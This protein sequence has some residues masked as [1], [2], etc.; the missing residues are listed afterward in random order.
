MKKRSSLLVIAILLSMI[1]PGV[2]PNTAQAAGSLVTKSYTAKM[3]TMELEGHIQYDGIHDNDGDGFLSIGRSN[4]EFGDVRLRAGVTFD[5]G[6]P[7]GNVVSAE[8]VLTVA[9]VIRNPDHT[10]YMEARG[11]AANELTESSF[12]AVDINSPYADKFTAKSIAEVPMGTYLQNQSITFNV[13]SAVDAFTDSSDRKI[14]FTLN[15]NEANAASG[16]FSIHSLE[17]FGNA[18][19]RPKLIVT[20]DTGVTA[21]NPLVGSFTITEG[22]ATSAGTVNLSVTG[23]DPDAGDSITHMRFA[24]SAAN[25]SAASWL[26]FSNT[27]T[28][29]LSGGDGSKTIYMQLK[30]SK[31]RISAN[32]SQTILLDQTAPIGTLIINDGATWTKSNE[33]TLKG[34]YTDGSGPGVEQVRLSNISGGSWQTSWFSIA[35]LNGKSWNLPVGEGTKTVY[36]QYKDKVGNVSTATISSTISVDTIAPIISNVEN[37]K[38]YKSKVIALFNEGFGL[39]NGSPYTSGTDITQDGTYTLTV[40]DPTGNSAMV[41]FKVDTTAPVVSGVTNNG[42]YKSNVTITFNKGTATLNGA[43]FSSGSQVALDGM[44][45]LVVT[46]AAGNVTTI[47]FEID[48]VAPTVTGVTNGWNYKEKVTVGFNEGTA[49]LNGAAF[50]S[51]TEIDQDGMYTLVVTDAVGNVTTVSF[52]IDSEDPIVTGVT[53]GGIYKGNVTVNFNEGTAK[54]NGAAFISGTQVVQD[55]V[56]T[57]VVTDAAGNETTITFEIDKLA[58]TVTGVT[59]NGDYKEAVTVTFNEGTA[60]LNSAPFAS[61]TEIDQDGVYTL[62]VTDAAGNVT[63]MNFKIDQSPPVVTGVVDGQVYNGKVTVSFNEGTATLNGVSFASGTAIIQDGTYTLVVTDE[64]GNVTTVSFEID[65]IAPIVTG[66]TN[67]G[68]YKEK[69]TVGFNEGTATLNGIAFTKGTE[70]VLD[71]AYTLVVTDEAGNITTIQFLLDT[72]TP[73]GTVII[74]SGVEWTNI[75][76]AILTLTSDDGIEGSGVVEMRFSSN[77]TDWSN[78]EPS[79]GTKGWTLE[80]GDG[81][82]KVFVQFKDKVGNVSSTVIYDSI[83]LDQTIPSGTMVINGGAATTSSKSVKLSLTSS[84]GVGSG[85]S[86]MRFSSD[87]LTWSIWESISSMKNWNLNGDTGVKKIFVQFRDVA[88]NMSETSNAVIEYQV[89]SGSD[90]KDSN[91]G[92]SGGAGNT[93]NTSNSTISSNGKITLPTGG[94]G[95]VSLNGEITISI[96]V[97]AT[98]KKLELEIEKVK[99]MQNMLNKK[100]ILASSV[101]EVDSNYLE[102]FKK[103]VTLTMSFDSLILN[104][105]KVVAIFYYDEASKGWL[106]VKDGKISGN[107]I[108]V[109]MIDHIKKKYAVLVVDK[110]SGLPAEQLIDRTTEANLNDV[111]GHWAETSIKKAMSEGI[112]KGYAD[113]SFRPN[114][115]VTRAEFAVMLINALKPEGNGNELSFIDNEKIGDWAHD[116]V[117]QAVQADIIKGYQDGTFR[118]NT[119]LTRAEMASIIANVLKLSVE[120]S[121]ATGFT[122][123]KSIPTWANNAVAQLNKLGLIEGKGRNKFEP[124]ATT[125][126]AEAVTVLLKMLVQVSK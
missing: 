3:D 56:Y 52:K 18:A 13:K 123:D 62:V 68:N 28:F 51:G 2:V 92:S 49:M 82:K 5:L 20:Y 12:P 96:P 9:T 75:T 112:V 37:G 81:E 65:K 44:H 27:A 63:T 100:E 110:V 98:T 38:V 104:N 50:A 73:I 83:K 17:T 47:T 10:L 32:S 76:N 61:G 23:S 120:S 41:N 60:T 24:N 126:R 43:A 72:N 94:A 117:A 101:Y 21:N 14:T 11:S 85:I 40:T 105:N 116:A 87:E 125:T 55:G 6:V 78:W 69:V 29:S 97:N 70:I 77:G 42:I 106:K 58:P 115:T 31:D 118:P 36:V 90:H 26:P 99:N 4:D 1:S 79:A 121:N 107:R 124:N 16:W 80:A 71:G 33:V 102:N 39:L 64:A 74:H 25:L 35:D 34:T 54:L 111:T 114:A 67:G 53:T 45:T 19:F 48:K 108:S 86:D 119:H 66:V 84:D 122:D 46:D 88:G 59:N 7:E 109:E 30:D 93:S 15:G 57:L 8:L 91:S 95:Q 89:S 113:G 22:A 103:S